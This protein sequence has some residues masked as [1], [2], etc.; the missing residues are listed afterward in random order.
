MEALAD[1]VGLWVI[2]LGLAVLDVVDRQVQLIVMRLGLATSCA[3][4]RPPGLLSARPL[5]VPLAPP[6]VRAAA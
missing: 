6:V 5:F 3:P 1:T 4:V 2:G